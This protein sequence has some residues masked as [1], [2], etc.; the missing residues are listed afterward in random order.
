MLAAPSLCVDNHNLVSLAR[1]M[2]GETYQPH[3]FPVRFMLLFS[4]AFACD[5]HSKAFIRRL[6][7][8]L[9]YENKQIM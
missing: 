6:Y 9:S 2:N 3:E 7:I 1:H 5:F 8:W 4:N